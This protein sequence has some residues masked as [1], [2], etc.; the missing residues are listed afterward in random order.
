MLPKLK[1]EVFELIP[2]VA[3]EP[4]L[5]MVPSH[6]KSDSATAPFAVPSDVSNRSA[7]GF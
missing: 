4:I 2:V 5:K 7:P 3:V 1:M 6:V